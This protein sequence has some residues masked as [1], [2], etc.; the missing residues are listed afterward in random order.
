M[1]RLAK[2]RK[3][4]VVSLMKDGIYEAAVRVL[5]ERGAEGLTMD[6]VAESAGVAKG[7]LYNYFR[8]K[9]E[10][11]QFIHEKTIEPAKD[12]L[13]EV[14]AASMPAAEKLQTVVRMW[15]EHFATNR[16][17]F[18]FLFNDPRTREVMEDCK[19]SS[20]L[21]GIEELRSFF[22]QGIAEGAFRPID[23]QR[24]AEMF[25]G[26]VILT[27]EQQLMLNLNRPAE[28]SAAALLDLF[29]NGLRPQ[30]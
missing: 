21:E 28:E 7:S 24:T 9:R 23:T 1:S 6:R 22:E 15:L 18:D 8:S 29:L 19:R 4:L 25:L 11:L 5:M 12:F 27:M 30:A 14:R 16:G 20:R 13:A 17:I 10:L 2:R 3:E 26:A